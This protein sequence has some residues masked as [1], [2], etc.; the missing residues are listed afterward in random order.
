[1]SQFS[2]EDTQSSSGD[3]D[4]TVDPQADCHQVR[5]PQEPR[6]VIYSYSFSLQ[7]YLPGRYLKRSHRH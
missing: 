6:G 5:L 3:I 1:M 7:L 4:K 2:V